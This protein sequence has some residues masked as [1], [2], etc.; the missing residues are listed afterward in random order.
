M[1]DRHRAVMPSWLALYYDEP[2]ELV[3]GEGRH[4][5]DADGNRYLDF[6]GGILTT[7]SG[8]DVPEVVDALR[9]Q[10][11]QAAA[12]VDALPERADGRARR[13]AVGAV[14]H[15]RRQGVLH[16]VGHRSQRSRAA[17]GDVVPAQQPGPRAAQ[18]LPRPVVRH[19]RDHRQPV[20]VADEPVRPAGARSCTAATGCAARSARSTTTRT[21]PR[22]C[23]TCATS[24][25]MCTSGDVAC[26][27]AEPI[28]GVGGFAT[29]PDGFFGAMEQGARRA[30][31]PLH[32]RRGADRLRPH[33]RPLLGLPGAR[34]RA[35]P[36]HVREGR[37]QR[38]HARRRDRP[39]RRARQRARQQHLDVRRQPA[40]V[41]G[42]ARQPRLPA[43]RTT[44][45]ATPASRARCSRTALRGARPT[46][47]RSSPRCAAAA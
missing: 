43:R 4:V 47:T 10:A 17:H 34:H 31:H 37:R 45:R 39:G 30:R 24:I 13:A 41:R 19:D 29:P 15:P 32:R 42:R 35:R 36:P 3:R 28:Q 7:I 14:G 1:R 16:D 44:C 12:H 5:W 38:A 11:G 26:M 27:I 18:Q 20:V 9:E 33:R 25:D 6:F 2:I 21:P 8:H 22:A 40:V 46:G 23:R